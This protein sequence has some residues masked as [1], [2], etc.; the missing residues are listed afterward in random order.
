M[1]PTRRARG[2]VRNKIVINRTRQPFS[3]ENRRFQ[4]LPLST[5]GSRR[6]HQKGQHL[7][8]SQDGFLKM[9]F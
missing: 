9:A 1:R 2:Q 6:R 8:L 7:Q 5:S 3:I 4:K